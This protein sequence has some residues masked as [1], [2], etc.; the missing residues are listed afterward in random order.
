[1][2]AQ[3][4]ELAP[5]EVT[6]RSAHLERNGFY[7]RSRLWGKQFTRADLDE[8]NPTRLSDILW[9]V[10]GVRVERRA[11]TALDPAA[12]SSSGLDELAEPA[13]LRFT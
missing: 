3:P 5:I 12:W 1:M 7:R 4:I 6:V 8:I 9:R 10:P 2:S 13:E 11:S